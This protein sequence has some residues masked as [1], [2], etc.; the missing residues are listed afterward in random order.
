[1]KALSDRDGD[2]AAVGGSG[3]L[4]TLRRVGTV[5]YG[6]LPQGSPCERLRCLWSRLWQYFVGRLPRLRNCY[7]LS[8][9]HHVAGFFPL[10][11]GHNDF[12]SLAAVVGADDS[13]FGHPVDHA[14]S[15]AVADS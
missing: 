5:Y 9:R 15:A 8:G 10:I 14:S 11:H 6:L 7:A 2:I 1:M 12:A 3:L 13:I 4:G